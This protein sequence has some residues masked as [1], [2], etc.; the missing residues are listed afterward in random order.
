VAPRHHFKKFRLAE[1]DRC[2]RV[3]APEGGVKPQIYGARLQLGLDVE[4][5]CCVVCF[6]L[7]FEERAYIAIR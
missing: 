2:P 7:Y 1:V 5:S 4:R 3:L 6:K